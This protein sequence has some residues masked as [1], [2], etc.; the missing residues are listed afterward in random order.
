MIALAIIITACSADEPTGGD[1]TMGPPVSKDF[2]GHEAVLM[3]DAT[4][5]EPRL[6]FATCNI[7]AENEDDAGCFFWW[8]DTEGHRQGGGFSF[9]YAN[10]DITT[11][12]RD[13]KLLHK[14]SIIAEES[15]KGILTPKYDAAAK[16]WGDSWRMP[17]KRDWQRLIDNC[18]WTWYTVSD[19]HCAG[20]EVS[21]KD[22]KGKIFLPAAGFYNGTKLSL[23]NESGRYW[24]SSPGGSSSD[25]YYI[26]FHSPIGSKGRNYSLGEASRYLGFSIRPIVSVE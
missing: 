3:V 15:E 22:G 26:G 16:L 12:G 25:A 24:S 7:G 18:D 14:W 10:D 4:D 13:Y 8:G 5:T 19:V 11:Y 2:N 21:R 17:T 20:Y 9:L 6:Y 1:I 23:K